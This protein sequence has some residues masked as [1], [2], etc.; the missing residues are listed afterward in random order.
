MTTRNEAAEGKQHRRL[1]VSFT[2]VIENT[3][4][5]S[6]AVMKVAAALAVAPN[7]TD[8]RRLNIGMQGIA[9][10]FPPE[11]SK[12]QPSDTIQTKQATSA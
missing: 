2:T 3:M 10:L 1:G 5:D 8:I 6:E 11:T 12:E 9:G 7:L 4:N